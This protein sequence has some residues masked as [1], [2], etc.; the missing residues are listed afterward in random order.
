MLGY[1]ETSNFIRKSRDRAGLIH[2][3]LLWLSHLLP[4]PPKGGAAQRSYHLIKSVSEHFNIDLVAFNQ[5]KIHKGKAQIDSAVVEFK[6]FC[7]DVHVFKIPSDTFYFGNSILAIKSLL[8]PLP[9]NINWLFS[10]EVHSFVKNLSKNKQYDLI[11]CDTISLIPYVKYFNAK[12]SILNHH[13]IESDT[14][15]RRS[16]NESNLFKKAYYKLE[17]VKLQKTEKKYCNFF[18]LNVTCSELDKYRLQS[19]LLSGKICIIPNGV[20]TDYF[21]ATARPQKPNSLIFAGTLSW[22]PNKQAVLFFIDKIWPLLKIKNP[23]V[24]ISFI[25]K[26]PP[27]RLIQLSK[28]CPQIKVTGFVDDVRPYIEEASVYV[29][30][31]MDG[32]GTKLKI[33]DALSMGKAIVAHPVACEGIDVRENEEVLFAETPEQFVD[34]IDFLLSNDFRFSMGIKGRSLIERLYSYKQI[35][36]TLITELKSLTADMAQEG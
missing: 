31:I 25:G 11:W 13:N 24:H 32:G 14:M 26:D 22:Y 20:D 36:K 10:P 6:K 29:C 2:M 1:P 7:S 4:F 5:R 18:S 19:R 3:N 35:G 33:L 17:G 27:E 16:E 8:S 23:L 21:K 28:K 12:V 30:P 15:F 9:Y 34:K